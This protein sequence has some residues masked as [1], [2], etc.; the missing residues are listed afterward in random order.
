MA[1]SSMQ[2]IRRISKPESEIDAEA[3]VE[4][5]PAA[6]PEAV[7]ESVDDGSIELNLD[8]IRKRAYSLSTLKKS[9][10]DY[11]WMW[12]EQELKLAK[13]LG[14]P[15]G[16][17]AKKVVVDAGKIVAKPKDNDIKKLA[18]D[19]AKKKAKVQDIHWFIAER[20]FIGDKALG[21]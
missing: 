16:P 2:G 9:Y 10:D 7:A 13:A 8:D 14:A 12:A 11:V 19:L 3:T 17:N 20:Q 5:E 6:E 15:L 4:E 18:A 21:H 1:P